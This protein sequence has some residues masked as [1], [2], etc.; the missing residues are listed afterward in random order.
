MCRDKFNGEGDDV[1]VKSCDSELLDEGEACWD[2]LGRMSSIRR[3]NRFT[4]PK[5]VCVHLKRQSFGFGLELTGRSPP[6]IASLC[7]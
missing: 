3:S 4:K 6:S 5:F 2:A 7:E 1:S